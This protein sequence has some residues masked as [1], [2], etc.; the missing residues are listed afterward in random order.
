MDLFRFNGSRNEFV[1]YLKHCVKWG[2]TLELTE[3]EKQILIN[4]ERIRLKKQFFDKY[5]LGD[6]Q[7]IDDLYQ[8]TCCL[9]DMAMEEYNANA[10]IQKQKQLK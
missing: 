7:E 4:E 2:F 5:Q 9:I 10:E 3:V 8:E 1:A 6:P